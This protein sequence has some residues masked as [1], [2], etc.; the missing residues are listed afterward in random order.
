[1][2]QSCP[3]ACRR[4]LTVCGHCSRS[5]QVVNA[6]CQTDHFVSGVE[7][8][9]TADDQVRVPTISPEGRKGAEVSDGIAMCVTTGMLHRVWGHTRRLAQY[10]RPMLGSVLL[11]SSAR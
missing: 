7:L 10:F 8:H 5:V 4:A 1:M 11:R 6:S 3:R 2:L 9:G